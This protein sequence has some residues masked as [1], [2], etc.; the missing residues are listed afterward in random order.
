MREHL[1]RVRS[2]DTPGLFFRRT[3]A[4]YADLDL[5]APEEFIEADVE[6]TDPRVNSDEAV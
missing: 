1:P 5:P 3:S 6:V 4:T 2:V